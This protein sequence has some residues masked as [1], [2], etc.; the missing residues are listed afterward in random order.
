M[1]LS[2]KYTVWYN[3]IVDRAMQRV[4]TNTYTEVHHII[5]K[6]L[7]GT[8]AADN[9]VRVT[10]REHFVC[11]RLLPKMTTGNNKR[12]MVYALWC[13]VNVKRK[14][15]ARYRVTSRE[16]LKIKEQH[17]IVCKLFKHSSETKQKISKIHKGKKVSNKTRQLMS[18]K[19][20]ARLNNTPEIIEK[21]KN[22][23]NKNGTTRAMLS[24]EANAKRAETRKNN[25]AL[26]NWIKSV[27]TPEAN[28]KRAASLRKTYIVISA[29]ST[30]YIV[31]NLKEF[32]LDNSLNYSAMCNLANNN[33]TSPHRGWNC[34]KLNL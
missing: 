14:D 8:N 15:Q 10:A 13:I 3:K 11:H 9:L 17:S 23:R 24:P 2:N 22:T 1:Y 26:D 6:A 28:A 31:S 4:S 20:K 25:G 7:G 27:C 12:K 21:A 30:E 32:C 16:Y 34:K 29:D 18:I 5:P 19:A 33:S